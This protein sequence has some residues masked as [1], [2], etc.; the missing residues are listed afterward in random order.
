M[1]GPTHRL[2]LWAVG[3]LG[4][5]RP[6]GTGSSAQPPSPQVF[7]SLH[8]S[9]PVSLSLLSPSLGLS[10]CCLF[11]SFLLSPL[12]PVYVSLSPSP[13]L[14]PQGM[15]TFSPQPPPPHTLRNGSLPEETFSPPGRSGCSRT[16]AWP[17][18]HWPLSWEENHRLSLFPRGGRGLCRETPLKHHCS[19]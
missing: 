11:I 3:V 14:P 5:L 12:T 2:V 13:P 6:G 15:H 4:G 19:P 10:L 16:R 17:W 18:A 1:P 8:F 9:L 7:V